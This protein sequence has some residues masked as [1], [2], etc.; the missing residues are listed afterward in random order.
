MAEHPNA[1]IYR[2]AFEA[3]L[4]QDEEAIRELIAEDVVWWEI[5]SPEPLHG[6]S[7]VMQ[8]MA[9]LEDVSFDVDVHDVTASDDHV[10]GMVTATVGVGGDEFTYRTA[11]IAHVK[12]GQITERWAFSDDTQR[13]IEFFSQFE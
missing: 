9:G 13:I 5:G 4:A 2:R 11:E 1:E 12:D 7:T 10:V 6:L 3:F 8:S